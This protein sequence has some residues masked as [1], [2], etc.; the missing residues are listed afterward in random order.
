M[1]PDPIEDALVDADPPPPPVAPLPIVLLTSTGVV[2]FKR[3]KPC[4]AAVVD[5]C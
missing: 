4:Y 2:Y 3:E 5:A 1:S